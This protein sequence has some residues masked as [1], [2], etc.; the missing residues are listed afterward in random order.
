MQLPYKSYRYLGNKG[1]I[2]EPFFLQSINFDPYNIDTNSRCFDEAY[3]GGNLNRGVVKRK[4]S[5]GAL[6]RSK[7][8]DVA[9]DE[10]EED[11][12][13]DE[14]ENY[15]DCE[16]DDVDDEVDDDFDNDDG[17][18]DDDENDGDGEDDDGVNNGK[19][20]ENDDDKENWD[21]CVETNDGIKS[22]GVKRQVEKNKT[23]VENKNN[24]IDN[25]F[26]LS[27]D[28]SKDQYPI[29]HRVKTAFKYNLSQKKRKKKN[30]ENN[31]KNN[32]EIIFNGRNN[33]Y[34]GI[35]SE[36]KDGII[37][38]NSKKVK[39]IEINLKKKKHKKCENKSG[40]KKKMK[41]S[42]IKLTRKRDINPSHQINNSINFSSNK[43]HLRN[44][45]YDIKTYLLQQPL[46][47]NLQNSP[48]FS[49]P[50][51]RRFL[52]KKSN[53]KASLKNQLT[54]P[55][56]HQ[57][58]QQ[59]QQLPFRLHHKHF[60]RNSLTFKGSYYNVYLKVAQ[61][62]PLMS[63]FLYKNFFINSFHFHSWDYSFSFF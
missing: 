58:V 45:R 13:D 4:R 12:E 35:T 10:G 56:L 2:S 57:S 11:G 22:F 61:C 46:H 34:E 43:N 36:K 28:I 37:K 32:N 62:P 49:P 42:N 52:A 6:K 1:K 30:N 54:T 41:K 48:S 8:G 15:D 33:S 51:L 16:N 60:F 53:H 17:Y 14:E 31:R 63:M 7:E 59:Q 47:N 23:N 29:Q 24:S 19:D 40:R 55:A 25:N 38:V 18:K 21:D 5:Y 44:Y 27:Y 9:K 3:N 26:G 50:Q 20:D 39:Q